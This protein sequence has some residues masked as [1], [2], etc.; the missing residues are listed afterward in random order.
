MVAAAE[1]PLRLSSA[2]AGRT[3]GEQAGRQVQGVAGTAGA[4]PDLG[5]GNSQGV[6]GRP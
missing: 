5:T 3:A 2:A 6:V 1:P 4:V